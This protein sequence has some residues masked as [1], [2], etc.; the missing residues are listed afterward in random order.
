[1]SEPMLAEIEIL[2]GNY[3]PRGWEFCHGQ[4]VNLMDYQAVYSLV[5]TTYGGD[6]RSTFGIPDLRGRVAV[7]YGAGPGRSQRIIGQFG[8]YEQVGLTVSQLPAHNHNAETAVSGEM[9]GKLKCVTENGTSSNPKGGYIASHTNAFLRSGTVEEMN[10]GSI[11]LDAGEL[12]AETSIEP[13][14]NNTAHE[15]MPP[16][17]CLNY[18]MAMEGYYP[19]RS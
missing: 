4:L 2:G 19:S 17:L 9:A 10:A 16:W 7:G 14:G 18:I 6:G 3:A 11:S 12:T 15:N 1:M 13:T 5:G 8:G